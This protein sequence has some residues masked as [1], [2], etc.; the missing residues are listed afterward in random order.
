MRIL[1]LSLISLL[2]LSPLAFCQLEVKNKTDDMLLHINSDGNTRINGSISDI[3]AILDAFST[4]MGFLPP[5][6]ST[7]QR[8]GITDPT[9]GLAIYNTTTK[10]IE[11]YTGAAGGWSS[12]CDCNWAPEVYRVRINGQLQQYQQLIGTYT[13]YDHESDPEGMSQFQWYRADD[14]S[15]LNQTPIPGAISSTYTLQEADIEKHI[16]LE[17]TP[18]AQTGTSPGMAAM[19][20]Y[21]GIIH[22]IGMTCGDMYD[23]SQ[24]VTTAGH[25][26]L[27]RNLGA[28]RVATSSS[29]YMAYGSLFQWGRLADGH[30]CLNWTS[31]LFTD[32]T[33]QSNESDTRCTN[34][35]A[36]DPCS[37][38]ADP[39]NYVV[40]HYNWTNRFY[41]HMQGTWWNGSTKGAAD[42]CPAGFRVPT[43]YELTDLKNSFSPQ[44]MEGAFNSPVKLPASGYRMYGNGEIWNSSY[45]GALWSSTYL[46]DNTRS[47]SLSFDRYNTSTGPSYRAAGFNIRCI[48]E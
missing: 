36:T 45:A 28:S 27:D 8:N 21:R 42:P 47:Y 22:G 31:F 7:S 9:E 38:L 25:T 34:N 29:D 41:S 43:R 14:A 19:S 40:T 39:S 10:C 16:A 1:V 17:V 5:R 33:E 15:G 46:D 23:Y 6:M 20:P 12:I 35:S 4:N 11:I 30:E 44:N 2:T 32:G 26:W 24:T 3:S 37:N 48:A 18:V 13:Y